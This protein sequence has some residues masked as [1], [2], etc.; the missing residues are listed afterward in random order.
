MIEN[1]V[2]VKTIQRQQDNRYMNVFQAVIEDSLAKNQII[3]NNETFT[4]REN[5]E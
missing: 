1:L 4:S 5:K 3:I 2:L